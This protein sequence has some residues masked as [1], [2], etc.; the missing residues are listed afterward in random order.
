MGAT[1]GS[2][3]YGNA[4]QLATT[5]REST[6][7]PLSPRLY[8]SS[9]IQ[10]LLG[11]FGEHIKQRISSQQEDAKTN[12]EQK[13]KKILVVRTH[14]G[15]FTKLSGPGGFVEYLPENGYEATEVLV[16]LGH[17]DAKFANDGKRWE[18]FEKFE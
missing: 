2:V 11:D 18:V 8:H 5:L 4:A 13:L 14:Y 12:P 15:H 3:E 7:Q 17:Q 16:P 6:F 10:T 9:Y 1:F